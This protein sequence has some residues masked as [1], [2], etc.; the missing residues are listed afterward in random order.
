MRLIGTAL[1]ALAGYVVTRMHLQHRDRAITGA[2][3][4]CEVYDG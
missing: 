3:G 1:G 2:D 4:C